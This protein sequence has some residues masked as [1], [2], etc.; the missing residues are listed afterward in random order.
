MPTSG[1]FIDLACAVRRACEG[2]TGEGET[3]LV[4]VQTDPIDS[5]RGMHAACRRV[6]QGF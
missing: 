6:V 1:S 5:G 2:E 3:G 4:K